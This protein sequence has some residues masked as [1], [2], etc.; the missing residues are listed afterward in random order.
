MYE[1]LWLGSQTSYDAYVQAK[2]LV[3]SNHSD[4]PDEPE[5]DLLSVQGSV[6]VINIQGSLINGNAGFMSY[7]GITG[8]G[9][10]RDALVAAVQH[11]EVTSI[12]LN[13]DSPGGQVSGCHETAQLIAR[14]GKVKP[15]VSYTGGVEASAA[16][17]TG[18]SAKYSFVA[19]TAPVGS[20]GIM[21]IH[22]DRTEQLKQDGIKVTVI[23]AGDKKALSN[24]YES[25]TE[26]ARKEMQAQADYLYA[27]FL[28]H[29][30]D[31][32]G[33]SSEV[34]DKAFGQGRM[35][36]GKQA[37][38]AGLI[39]AVG[40]LEDAYAKALSYGQ[41]VAAR[42][43][44]A[45]QGPTTIVRAAVEEVLSA[46]L[47]QVS[48]AEVDNVHNAVDNP[49]NEQ[50]T[51]MP[52]PAQS[53]S[54][55][56]LAAMAAGV[57]LEAVADPVKEAAEAA[58]VAEAATAEE[59]ARVAAAKLAAEAV[60]ASTGGELLAYLQGENGKLQL[61]NATATVALA[62]AN[63]AIEKTKPQLDALTEIARASVRTMTVA[64]GGKAE[65][66]AAMSAEDVVAEHT[67]VTEV[68]K[69]KFKVGAVAATNTVEDPV[70]TQ[71]QVDPLFL[72]RLKS[73]S[74]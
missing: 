68:F 57:T 52:K 10:I 73:L 17:W 67:R 46:N 18:S 19:E 1:N 48:G 5:A 44:A 39:D 2:A 13:I 41:K 45:P 4:T 16:L 70:P 24:P 38:V 36:L 27:I 20:L 22:T 63:A 11:A 8:Y 15:V 72:A 31:Q 14:V 51:P 50:G 58:A 29:V 62:T 33:V 56:E 3:L 65:A 49:P 32:R 61:A 71:A 7:Y 43:T 47:T 21:A 53:L 69:S 30:A 60:A 23:R 9:D 34:A 37:V 35:F 25:L 54:H 28:G 40:T 66:V 12:L 59:A 64:L 6:G 42:A 74:K 26:E 55:A